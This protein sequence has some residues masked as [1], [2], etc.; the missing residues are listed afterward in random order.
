MSDVDAD[1][2]SGTVSASQPG[3]VVG[4]SQV[5][6]TV[7][8]RLA[9]PQANLWTPAQLGSD[10]ALWLDVWDSPFDLRTD[11]GTDYVERWGDLSGNG[12]DATQATGSEQPVLDNAVKCGNRHLVVGDLQEVAGVDAF[13][14]FALYKVR[15]SGSF[16]MVM[17]KVKQK[18]GEFEIRR[19]DDDTLFTQ[20]ETTNNLFARQLGGSL[21]SGEIA[22]HVSEYDGATFRQ[23]QDGDTV[24]SK[25]LT[26]TT[27]DSSFELA[28]GHRL[29]GDFSGN[30]DIWAAVVATVD[31]AVLIEG[32]AAHAADRE[33]GITEP[34]NN[35]PSSHPYK[36]DPPRV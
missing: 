22:L 32:W 14:V 26:G 35:L 18:D 28:I 30:V 31:Q 11:G 3:G 25:P 12:H 36:D 15:T 29:N 1:Q 27:L 24:S 17:S 19:N 10:L 8:A 33:L 4:A 34:L 20:T 13:T 6:G 21:L 16:E 7:G 23:R 2:V 9:Q 5:R